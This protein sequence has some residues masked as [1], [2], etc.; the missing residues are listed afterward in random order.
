L[1]T[2]IAH[3]A[4]DLG[5]ESGRAIVGC[6][7]GESLSL[8]E[9]H[10][11]P[12]RM[13]RLPSGLHWDLTGL[14]SG[15][16]EGIARALTWSREHSVHLRSVGVDTWGVDYALLGR[17]GELLGLPH[18]YRDPRNA[19]AFEQVVEAVGEAAVYE[20]T[21]IQLLELNTLYQ[22]VAQHEAEPALVGAAER[23]AHGRL[24][25]RPAG[26]GGLADGDAGTDPPAGHDD[27]SAA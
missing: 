21:G 11:F 15:V 4:I 1:T 2:R 26:A 6:L 27:R 16:L 12:N 8:H 10:R 7:D 22:L 9:V 25:H 13:C 5:A 14:W 23:S 3:L 18:C 24:G 19:A 20:A 17:S